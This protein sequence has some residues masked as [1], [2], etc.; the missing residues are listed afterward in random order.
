MHKRNSMQKDIQQKHAVPVN[1]SY[2]IVLDLV[3]IRNQ[4]D[5]SE[6]DF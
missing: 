2:F 5:H 4:S 3:I 1:F 6:V